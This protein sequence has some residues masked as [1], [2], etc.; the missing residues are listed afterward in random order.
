VLWQSILSEVQGNEVFAPLT[1]SNH[2][3]E[4]RNLLAKKKICQDHIIQQADMDE[5]K[6][7]QA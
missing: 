7:H 5:G 4:R 1:K 3:G 2:G 6:F